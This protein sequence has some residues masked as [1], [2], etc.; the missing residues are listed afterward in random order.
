MNRET[1]SATPVPGVPEETASNG[2]ETA[3]AAIFARVFHTIRPRSAVP[4]IRV[5]F[6]RFAN[7]NCFIQLQHGQ[8]DI[9]MTDVLRTAP[10]EVVESLAFILVS[11]LYRRPPPK[12]HTQRYRRFLSKKPVRAA[13]SHVRQERG[14]KQIAPPGG[15]H[16][17]LAEVFEDVNFKYFHGLMARPQLGWSLRPSR[18]TL[19]HYDPSHHAIVINRILDSPSAPL[20]ALQFVMYHEMLHVKYPAEQRSGRRCVHTKDF[21]RAEREFEGYEEVTEMLRHL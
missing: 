4:A 6:S 8:A 20:L 11:K 14:R 15:N 18:Q 16:H 10:Y 3:A 1:A 17:D 12:E 9:R 5:K 19:G 2:A 13:I 7:A 21:K